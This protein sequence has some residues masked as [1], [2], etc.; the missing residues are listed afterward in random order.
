MKQHVRG[1]L[2]SIGASV[3]WGFS[4]ACVQCLTAHYEIDALELISIRMLSAG[5]ILLIF[6]AWRNQT[7][8][9][10][11]LRDIKTLASLAIFGIIGVFM[12]Q[13][14]YIQAIATTNAGTATVLCCL[15]AVILLVAVCLTQR[16]APR[17]VEVIGVL[18]AMVAVWLIATGGNPAN[19]AVSPLGLFWGITAAVAIAFYTIYSKPIMASVGNIPALAIGM[20]FGGMTSTAC[21]LPHWSMPELDL[22]GVALIAIVVICGTVITFALYFQAVLDLEA[23][24][25][26]MLSVVEPMVATALSTIWLGTAFAMSDYVA[27]ALMFAMVFLISH[28]GSNAHRTRTHRMRAH[29]LSA[30]RVAQM[31]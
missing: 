12:S 29:R 7:L 22:F 10:E 27:F 20:L 6:A 25:V 8:R 11:A 18:L 30:H 14:T 9:I 2:C 4:G 3:T 19:L 28:A 26:G 31:P 17:A 21:S 24:E 15:N 13:L 23:V 16:K 5:A 1:L